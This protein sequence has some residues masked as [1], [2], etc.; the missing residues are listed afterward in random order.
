MRHIQ[1][2]AC[3]IQGYA[4]VGISDALFQRLL[5]ISDSYSWIGLWSIDYDVT[6]IPADI[7]GTLDKRANNFYNIPELIQGVINQTPYHDLV[8]VG[9]PVYQVVG[10]CRGSYNPFQSDSTGLLDYHRVLTQAE[11]PVF[12]QSQLSQY[13][14][15]IMQT[16]GILLP[17]TTI[18]EFNPTPIVTLPSWVGVITN[19]VINTPA[20]AGSQR[21]AKAAIGS[22]Q[23]PCQTGFQ[24]S[25]QLGDGRQAPPDNYDQTGKNQ[26]T[27][28]TI[29]GVTAGQVDISGAKVSVPAQ[30]QSRTFA[31]SDQQI[32]N[33]IN[34]VL[35][36]A[37][38]QYDFQQGA[39]T[40]VGHTYR[41]KN[42]AIQHNDKFTLWAYLGSVSLYCQAQR[43]QK[44]QCALNIS[45]PQCSP[46]MIQQAVMTDLPKDND[47]TTVYVYSYKVN[48][49]I[50]GWMAVK[51]C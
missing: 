40:Y 16:P 34:S 41:R 3:G 4:C 13:G 50:M 47:D 42:D 35:V 49:N 37:Q 1:A 24:I 18:S 21:I 25:A 7:G 15:G 32:S 39:Y 48:S 8:N 28:F 29:T 31:F 22:N 30:T 19:N 20:V 9:A 14:P 38:L 44:K 51:D 2:Q 27:S 26:G 33:Q 10:R 43:G 6:P 46:I 45:Q 36:Y 23:S 11:P 12:S 17:Q 5:N